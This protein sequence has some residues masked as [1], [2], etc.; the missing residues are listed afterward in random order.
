MWACVG[1]RGA[2]RREP[3]RG[4]AACHRDDEE[5]AKD[6]RGRV[7]VH[8]EHDRRD[9]REE[10]GALADLRDAVV[11]LLDERRVLGVHAEGDE[12]H[13]LPAD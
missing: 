9:E 3:M 4:A 7:T 12:A 1:L 10:E 5:T 6:V 13:E 2:R 8:P 11:A